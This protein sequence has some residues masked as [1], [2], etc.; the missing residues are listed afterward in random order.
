M[1]ETGTVQST[2]GA[3]WRAAGEGS[4][5]GEPRENFGLL[6]QGTAKSRDMCSAHL[7][8]PLTTFFHPTWGRDP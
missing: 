2:E 3:A 6:D 1:S 8:M 5:E 4:R 7:T